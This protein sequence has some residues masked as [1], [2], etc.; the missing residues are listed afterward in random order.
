MH[1]IVSTC[2]A[3]TYGQILFLLKKGHN[4]SLAMGEKPKQP[5]QCVNTIS[6]LHHARGRAL[7]I[8][9]YFKD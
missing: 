7:V 1:N 3:L 8:N 4:I 5:R 2:K 9:V 6:F